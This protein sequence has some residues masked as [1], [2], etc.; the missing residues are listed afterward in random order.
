MILLAMDP[1]IYLT[2]I[3]AAAAIGVEQIEDVAN[4]LLLYF[5]PPLQTI[6]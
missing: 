4:L 2:P 6:K 3:D 5:P 1:K